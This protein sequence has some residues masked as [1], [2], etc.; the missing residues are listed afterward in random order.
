MAQIDSDTPPKSHAPQEATVE[1]KAP[2]TKVDQLQPSLATASATDT[3]Y[4]VEQQNT[5]TTHTPS[6]DEAWSP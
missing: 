1:N 5:G 2:T 6:Q 4:E 3:E